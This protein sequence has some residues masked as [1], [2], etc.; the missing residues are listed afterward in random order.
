MTFRKVLN[1]SAKAASHL[2]LT[3]VGVAGQAIS[4]APSWQRAAPQSTAWFC[5]H[6]AYRDPLLWVEAPLRFQQ[7]GFRRLFARYL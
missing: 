1:E 2:Y 5:G 6:A 7:R 3:P 4:G